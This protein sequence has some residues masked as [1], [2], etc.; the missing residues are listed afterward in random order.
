[1][2]K[3]EVVMNKCYGG[4]ELSKRAVIRLNELTG[5]NMDDGYEY[6]K[7]ERRSDPYLIQVVKELGRGASD[8]C[9][10]LRVVEICISEFE[11]YD[12]IE[13]LDIRKIYE[14]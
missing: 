9:S 3:I 11:D 13:S 1:M 14:G 5:K 4:F 7:I 12:G 8:R 2:L 10:D 6:S